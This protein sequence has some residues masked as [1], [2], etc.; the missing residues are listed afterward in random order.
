[1][2]S[3]RKI[4]EVVDEIYVV[5]ES[6]AEL[7]E[8]IAEKVDELFEHQKAFISSTEKTISKLT[9]AISGYL[10]RATYQIERVER[11]YDN[12]VTE[13]DAIISRLEKARKKLYDTEHE[14]LA[15]FRKIRMKVLVSTV[16]LGGIGIFLLGLNFYLSKKS[17]E[18]YSAIK[19][20]PT[21]F[22]EKGE[23]YVK[24]KPRTESTWTHQ[25]KKVTFAKMA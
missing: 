10:D 4:Q 13:G 18:K 21:T 23:H 2:S 25:G 11:V 3:M 6:T 16:V 15:K 19:G 1:M 24:V 12:I 9:T 8:E 5:K 17:Y 20:I 14:R 7:N 22:E